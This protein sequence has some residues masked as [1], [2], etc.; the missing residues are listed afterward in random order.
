MRR[1][2]VLLVP[3][4]AVLAC[5]PTAKPTPTPPG[6]PGGD[7]PPAGGDAPRATT[8]E[9]T[10]HGSLALPGPIVFATG[11]AELD[12]AASEAALQ[13]VHDYLVA[14]DAVTL[15]RIEGHGDQSGEDALML[16][17]DRALAV[18]RWLVAH[19]IACER[20]LAAAFGDTKPIADSSTAEGRAANRRIEIVNAELRGKA[21]GGMPVDG[22]APAAVPVCD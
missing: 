16:S 19:D 1:S 5:G 20:L 7:T 12:L 6:P 11:S 8:F 15:V 3:L 10:D 17:G 9:M 18:G 4:L 2:F 22:G 21:I 14:K 13:H